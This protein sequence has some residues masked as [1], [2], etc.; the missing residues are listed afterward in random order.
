MGDSRETSVFM[1]M[2]E[3]R[4]LFGTYAAYL[5]H[6][7]AAIPSNAT[8]EWSYEVR[9]GAEA[10]PKVA[11]SRLPCVDCGRNMRETEWAQAIVYGFPPARD[12]WRGCRNRSSARRWFNY[13]S[14]N[15]TNISFGGSGRDGII[16]AN[17]SVGFD[18]A[19]VEYIQKLNSPD[20]PPSLMW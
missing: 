7:E 1:A 9:G 12:V 20:T 13:W 3:F 4:I 10:W 11:T 19:F 17:S 6:P 2:A 18:F 16:F 14:R 5:F 8:D 15:Q